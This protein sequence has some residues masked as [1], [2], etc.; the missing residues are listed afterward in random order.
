MTMKR[1]K[2]LHRFSAVTAILLAFCLV[3]MMPVGAVGEVSVWNGESFDT[4]WYTTNPDANE[5]TI[6]SAAQLAGLASLVNDAE[7]PVDFAGKTIKLGAD[8]DLDGKQWTP[9]GYWQTFE[10]TFDGQEH[11]ISNLKHHAT[12]LDCYIGLFGCTLD[13]TIKNLYIHNADIKLIG[14]DS[15][16]GGQSGALVGFPD[17]ISTIENIKLTGTVKIEGATDKLG[18]QRIGAVVGGFGEESLA[19]MTMSNIVVDVTS[20]SYVKGYLFVGGVAGAPLLTITMT[21]VQSN[22]NVFSTTGIVGGIIGYAQKD[23]SFTNCISTGNV[24]RVETTSDNTENQIMRIGGIVGSWCGGAGSV[25]LTGCSHTG[26][27]SAKDTSGADITEFE[28]GNLVGRWYS[29]PTSGNLV[30]D[31]CSNKIIQ[32]SEDV[33]VYYITTPDALFDFA[34][35]V[36]EGNTYSGKTIVLTQNIDLNNKEWTPIGTSTNP[37][38]GSFDGNEQ[39]ISNLL[40]NSPDGEKLG[41]FGVVA[42][43][44]DSSVEQFIKDVT[45]HNVQ[46]NGKQEIGALIGFSNTD[47]NKITLSNCHVTGLVQITGKTQQGGLLGIT[48]IH[49]ITSCSVNADD[50]SFVKGEYSGEKLEGDNSGGLIGQVEYN[51]DY[52]G[53]QT[54]FPITIS[55]CSANIDVS[56]SRKVGGLIGAFVDGDI[57]DCSASGDVTIIH[58]EDYDVTLLSVGSLIGDVHYPHG[59]SIV[60]TTATGTINIADT[61]SKE[62]VSAGFVGAVRHNSPET[63]HL[64]YNDDDYI[65]GVATSVTNSVWNA[66][67]ISEILSYYNTISIGTLKISAGTYTADVSDYVAEGYVCISQDAETYVVTAKEIS[68]KP[69]VTSVSFGTVQEGYTPTTAK[70]TLTNTGNVA[71]DFKVEGVSKHFTVSQTPA[72]NNLKLDESCVISITP[73]SK[74]TEGTYSETLTIQVGEE[75][76]LKIPV[77]IMVIEEIKGDEKETTVVPELP[78]V[79]VEG[80]ETETKSIVVDTTYSNKVII[81][82]SEGEN[83]GA[84]ATKTVTISASSSS[85]SDDDEPTPSVSVVITRVKQTENKLELT[86]ESEVSAEYTDVKSE[87]SES[88]SEQQT[89]SFDISIPLKTV[90][91]TTLPVFSGK[92]DEKIAEK[93]PEKDE[94]GKKFTPLAMFTATKNADEVSK[95]VKGGP[96]S[97]SITVTFYITD[98]L[99]GKFVAF[100]VKNGELIGDPIEATVG[101][102]IEGKGYPVTITVAGFSSYVLAEVQDPSNGNTG[103][104]ATDTGSGNYQYY[105]RDVPSSGIISFGTSKVVTGMELPAGSD[106]TVTL[107]IKPTFAMPENG[108]YAFEIDA[109]GYNLDAK[110]NGGLSFQ[111]PVTDLEAAGFTAED[112][113]LFHGTVGEDGK[114]TWEQLPTYLNKVENGIAYYKAAI[115]GCSPFYIGFVKDGSIINTEVVDPVTPETPV[116][117]DEP[118]VLPPADEPQDEPETPAS[119]APIL[120]VLAGLGAVTALRRM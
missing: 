74:L 21:D 27:L 91:T 45:I 82:P 7:N 49:D 112:I 36:N 95:N 83:D 29:E 73:D 113:V 107:N 38:K 43:S 67:D 100:H 118:E 64:K 89:V 56:G 68:I 62:F 12:E 116:T 110:I 61:D 46:I 120:A 93:I 117:P 94:D 81:E 84:E 105:P 34:K 65:S 16:A 22:V 69:D 28:N 15:W 13:A 75:S 24:V 88:A 92:Y 86:A 96:D 30:I 14:D 115:N 106:G 111:I 3:F 25:T 54:Y 98:K 35:S 50:G 48:N 90:N 42:K 60:D 101:D 8:I 97:P 5:F 57:K 77:T 72:G 76:S 47:G 41:L 103:G 85:T 79:A 10:G 23:S 33:N 32:D 17:G 31:G 71:T 70:V 39:T 19:S 87:T 66:G 119:P 37:F 59:I 6:S 109:P 80:T 4:S 52:Y 40:I 1:Q 11:T 51:H 9:I 102:Y 2:T 26:T 99:G 18:G 53:T 20:D 55:S 114:I 44:D 108:F 104:S 78:P 58:V 63:G